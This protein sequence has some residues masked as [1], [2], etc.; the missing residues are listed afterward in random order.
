ME[1]QWK[2]IPNDY[3]RCAVR[4]VQNQEQTI[5]LRLTEGMPDVGRVLCAWGQ[6]QLREKQWRTE[7][8]S[9][10]G[11]VNAWVL[12]IPEDGSQPRCVEG[13]IPFQSKWKLPINTREGFIRADV[14]LRSIDARAISS[15]KLLIRVS[16]SIMG[17]ALE[18]QEMAVSQPQEMPEGI[19]M[20]QQT[21][22][23]Q[24]AVEA[25]E[26]LFSMEE[27][28]SITA[29][30]QVKIL[31]CRA[32]SQITEQA[33]TG[34]R[35][36]L[37]GLLRVHYVYLGEDDQ[38]RSGSQELPFAQFADLDH[39]HDKEATVTANIAFADAICTQE[40]DT[41]QIKCDLIAQYVIHDRC[42]LQITEDAYSPHRNVTPSVSQ[43]EI[44]VLLDRIKETVIAELEMPLDVRNVVDVTFFSDHPVYYWENDMTV[45]EIPGTF[46]TLFYDVEGNLQS[47]IE[48]WA[49]H[50]Q[51]G[52][53]A[54]CSFAI[55]AEQTS[56]PTAMPFG[57]QLRVHA[58]LAVNVQTGTVQTMNM[59]TGIE[60]GEMSPP[61]L[62]RP[63]VILR[64]ADGLSLWE[65][66]KGC[67][68]SVEAIEKTNG[69]SGQPEPEKMLLIPVI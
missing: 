34:G 30:Q 9:I 54:N 20:L 45:V 58:D 31:C 33:V 8:I 68:S 27:S 65:L 17:E 48:T 67:G 41:L 1:M 46:Q 22:P 2:S 56:L 42:L 40:G 43:L 25:G 18:Q 53:G 7:D 66:A 69:L 4:E 51:F 61:D 15:R 29:D 11:G 16:L 14:R 50:W 38:L 10:K 6:P 64:K 28:L 21:Y 35:I 60:V 52:A 24:L 26:K 19:Y 37:R 23:M 44:P 5:E 12:Y 39:D 57:E 63:S 55:S 59:V 36:V 62:K 49:G 3:L 32:Y 47:G 13:W